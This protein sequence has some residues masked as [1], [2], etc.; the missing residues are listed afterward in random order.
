MTA[1]SLRDA[2][3]RAWRLATGGNALEVC[4]LAA[5]AL[6]VVATLVATARAGFAQASREDLAL[7]G[8]LEETEALIENQ[9]SSGIARYQRGLLELGGRR[10][11]LDSLAVSGDS[12]LFPSLA[13]GGFLR[14]QIEAFNDHAARHALAAARLG[15]NGQA[16][17]SPSLFHL[18]RS[19]SGYHYLSSQLNGYALLVPSPFA[20]RQWTTVRT[21]DWGSGA[22]VMG[23]LED[24]A[25]FA[26]DSALSAPSRLSGVDCRVKE[27]GPLS[28][29]LYCRSAAGSDIG[30]AYDLGFQLRREASF[31]DGAA[32]RSERQA[33]IWWNGRRGAVPDVV[34]SGDVIYSDAVGPLVLSDVRSGILAAPQ[35]L[36]GRSAFTLARSGT[37]QFFGRA[38]R[39][40]DGEV[41]A[42]PLTL[43]L[44]AR[45]SR[46]LD[47]RI[48]AFTARNAAYLEGVTIVVADVRTGE[49][50][51]VAESGSRAG[52]PLRAFEPVLLGSMVKPILAAALLSQDPALE[53]LTVRWSGPEV[54]QVAGIPLRV[55]FRNPLN[56]CGEVIDF[57]TFLGCS[58]NEYA[59]ALLFESLQ[60]SAGRRDIAPEGVVA[61]DL[62][63]HTSLTNGV[64]SLFDD[65]DV[66]SVRTPGRSDRLWRADATSAAARHVPRDR[67]LYPW[68][69]RPWFIYPESRGTP[70][71]WLARFA[72]GGWENRWTLLGAAEAY[73]RISTGRDVQLTLLDRSGQDDLFAPA[74]PPAAAAFSAVRGGL[75][76]VGESGTARGLTAA[77][78]TVG[79]PSDSLRVLSKTGTLNE[80]TS[81]LQ[82]D[83]VF[84]KSLAMV[85]GR[86][87]DGGPAAAVDC[88]LVILS[89]FEF[90]QDWRSAPGATAATALPDLH[91]DFATTELAPALRDS[92]KRMG[93]CPPRMVSAP[94]A[95]ATRP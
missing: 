38:G 82:D 85:V 46:A 43:S 34:R 7:R 25:F 95:T 23:L 19:D 90:R 15:A 28:R 50:K 67:T 22:A 75:E 59:V 89:Y 94:P 63:E 47:R 52:R 79:P 36:N 76:L 81:R 35:W 84:L 70:V 73:A 5:A 27:A 80:I 92:W 4:L 77:L 31:V 88:G 18:A 91:R 44:D 68:T 87:V 58:S 93:V 54:S 9:G 45:L 1:R 6:A 65:A 8:A 29:L 17:P 24:A 69:S 2:S 66:V 16:D 12:L 11:V 74:Q 51:A 20:E 3:A 10:Y 33:P 14:D 21:A 41:G 40:V 71:D 78:R 48:D 86:T 37:L 49:V 62:L 83:D 64:L 56:G 26:G 13:K 42:E 30:A 53:R 32:V 57:R 39:A 72:F 60:R 61:T 55:P